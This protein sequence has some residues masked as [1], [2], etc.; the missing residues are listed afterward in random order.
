MNDRVPA[1]SAPR[2][3]V[4]P[5]KTKVVHTEAFGAVT[6][7]AMSIRRAREIATQLDENRPEESGFRLL[8]ETATGP[9]GERFTMESIDEFPAHVM[10]EINL[11]VNEAAEL[12]R[13]TPADAKKD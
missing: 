11:L 6:L 3:F 4:V 8:C 2:E 7:R 5:S 1:L 12:S 10:A 9:N 13:A